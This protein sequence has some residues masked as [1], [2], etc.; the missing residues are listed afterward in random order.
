MSTF[1]LVVG[2]LSLLIGSVG[3]MNIMLVTVQ[4]RTREIGLR[5]AVGASYTTILSQFLLETTVICLIGGFVGT[6]GAV[7]ASRY[8][9]RLPEEAQ[10]PDPVV[11]PVAVLAAVVITLGVALAAGLYPAARAA[12]LDPIRALRFD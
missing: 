8:L 12:A 10:V 5:K 9:A 1:L 3:V 11:T 4:E 7:V 6:L 2:M